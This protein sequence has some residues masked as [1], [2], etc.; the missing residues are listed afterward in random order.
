MPTSLQQYNDGMFVLPLTLCHPVEEL[1]TQ[2]G[3]NSKGINTQL[4]LEVQG[5]TP[6][7][8]DADHQ[9]TASISTYVL[10]ETTAQLRIG[11]GRNIGVAF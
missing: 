10:A 7:T 6:P 2:S 9:T 3:Y 4:T 8:A 11:L 5:Q 1:H